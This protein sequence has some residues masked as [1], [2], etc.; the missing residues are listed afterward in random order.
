[1]MN[2]YLKRVSKR[3]RVVAPDPEGS[4][5]TSP[6][7][8]RLLRGGNSVNVSPVTLSRRPAYQNEAKEN[9]FEIK[10]YFTIECKLENNL[11]FAIALHLQY[12]RLLAERMPSVGFHNN[13]QH[14]QNR[15]VVLYK[16]LEVR[17]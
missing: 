12:K 11:I 3:L 15:T 8:P 4:V 16:D 14:L 10:M 2:M 6:R 7:F 1:M 13:K 17:T 9:V 5:I